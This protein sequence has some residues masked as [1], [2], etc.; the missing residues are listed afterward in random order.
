MKLA[1]F[2]NQFIEG[3]LFADLSTMVSAGPSD[4]SA[5]SFRLPN[6]HDLRIGA[7]DPRNARRNSL[8]G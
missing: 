4:R 3:Y 2:L 5:R 1:D 6:A 8:P 7:R